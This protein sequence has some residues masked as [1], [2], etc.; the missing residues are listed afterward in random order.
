MNSIP[1]SVL[2]ALE[3]AR[4]SSEYNMMHRTAVIGW[5]AALEE[6]NWE[7]WGGA[8]NWLYDNPGRYMEALKAMGEQRTK[9]DA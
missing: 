5:I 6:E 1:K 8:S 3:A 9:P 7:S 4:A 2:T